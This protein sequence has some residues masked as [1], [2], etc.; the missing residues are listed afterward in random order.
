[1]KSELGVD[2]LEPI[3]R[4]SLWISDSLKIRVVGTH[5][6][7]NLESD[8]GGELTETEENPIYRNHRA[9]DLGR[10]HFGNVL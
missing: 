8:R 6:V 3:G 1:M 4:V 7:D 9:S 5:T 2:T 10:R